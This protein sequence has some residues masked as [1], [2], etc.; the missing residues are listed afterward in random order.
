MRILRGL[1]RLADQGF[2][3]RNPPGHPLDHLVLRKQQVVLLGL[4]Q[5][6]KR[7]RGHRQFESPPNAARKPFLP[8]R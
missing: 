4:G 1:A 7:G 8:T 5:Y 6:M 2:Q 3:F